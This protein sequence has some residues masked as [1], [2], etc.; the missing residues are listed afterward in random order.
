MHKTMHLGD[1]LQHG[2]NFRANLVRWL[3]CLTT[4]LAAISTSVAA[5]PRGLVVSVAASVNDVLAEI[6]TLYRAATGVTVAVNPGGSHTLARQIVEGAKVHLFLSADETQM[7]VVE[8]AGRIASGTRTRLL[9]NELAVIA[10]ATATSIT[11]ERVIEG[12]INRLAIGEPAAVP[13]GVYARRFLEHENAWTR[14]EPKVVPFPTVTAV[15][16][17]V[18]T[19]RVD[20][21]IVYRT[22]AMR[23]T[24]VRV[25]AA[26]S[27]R[28]HPYLDIS[29]P[30][31]VIA[32]AGETDSRKFL[33]YL[34]GPVARAVFE[35]HGFVLA[36]APR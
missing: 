28:D 23:S 10:P 5:Q 35:R 36:P 11:L 14:L 24:D 31:A 4:V 32:G 6:A 12:R 16:S 18:A 7:D 15:L 30:V 13:A 20:A 19:G 3:L 27:R 17:A 1:C 2:L 9:T 8:K 21:G 33:E 26:V 34:K 25:I 22:D 29:Y